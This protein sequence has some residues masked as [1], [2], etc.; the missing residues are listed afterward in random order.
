MNPV[1][2]AAPCTTGANQSESPIVGEE[3]GVSNMAA[4]T[5]FPTSSCLPTTTSPTSADA[6]SPPRLPHRPSSPWS[7]LT[8]WRHVNPLTAT[9][10][11]L[12][13]TLTTSSLRPRPARVAS[14]PTYEEVAR[15]LAELRRQLDQR[16]AHQESRTASPWRQADQERQTDARE[17]VPRPASMSAALPSTEAPPPPSRG[18]EPSTAFREGPTQQLGELCVPIGPEPL[19]RELVKGV[20]PVPIVRLRPSSN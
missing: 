7:F 4:T 9:A 20:D 18:P 17:E 11:T 3:P 12:A 19:L 16:T 10:V 14:Q 2:S 1:I 6:V 13:A 8:G 15:E 5:S